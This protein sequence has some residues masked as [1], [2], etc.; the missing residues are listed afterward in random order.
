MSPKGLKNHKYTCFAN[1]SLQALF[2]VPELLEHYEACE[3]VLSDEVW[4]MF[5]A[6]TNLPRAQKASKTPVKQRDQLR[7]LVED[8]W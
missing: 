2:G 6:Y 3:K 7:S 8:K 1:A 5:T 4:S